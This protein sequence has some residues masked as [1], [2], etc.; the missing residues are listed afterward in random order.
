MTK[1]PKRS[2][3]ASPGHFP[4][5]PPPARIIRVEVRAAQ[6]L[7]AAVRTPFNVAA[8]VVPYADSRAAIGTGSAFHDQML[9]GFLLHLATAAYAPACVRRNRP[10]RL[11]PS[12]T[13]LSAGGGLTI[14]STSAASR[15]TYI[16]LKSGTTT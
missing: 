4:V 13:T 6:R 12:V 8:T 16:T 5:H 10:E 11:P 7:P 3:S 14:R 9:L 1:K 15:S 2:Q